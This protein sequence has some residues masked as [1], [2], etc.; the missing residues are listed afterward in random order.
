MLVLFSYNLGVIYLMKTIDAMMEKIDKSKCHWNTRLKM[1]K[2]MRKGKYSRLTKI[3]LNPQATLNTVLVSTKLRR[4]T[5]MTLDFI[6][7][8]TNGSIFLTHI[9]CR[10]FKMTEQFAS[11][12]VV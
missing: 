5:K 3:S 7:S 6:F 1:Q 8:K 12:T 10:I 4:K 9:W 2:V 11:R